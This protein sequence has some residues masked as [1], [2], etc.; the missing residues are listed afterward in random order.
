MIGQTF[1]AGRMGR[2]LPARR[3]G[4]LF[5]GIFTLAM[6]AILFAQR[7]SMNALFEAEGVTRDLKRHGWRRGPAVRPG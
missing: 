4:L 5:C 1:D 3:D 2:V 7:G 6:T